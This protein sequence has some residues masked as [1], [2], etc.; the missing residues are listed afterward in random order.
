MEELSNNKME[1]VMTE[2]WEKFFRCIFQSKK[3]SYD[4]Y[5]VYQSLLK[6]Y[7]KECVVKNYSLDFY[8]SNFRKIKFIYKTYDDI[9]DFIVAGTLNDR[10]DFT[11]FKKIGNI[12]KE[13]IEIEMQNNKIEISK[14]DENYFNNIK[15]IKF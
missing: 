7:F 10:L 12:V 14:F 15:N 3:K 9:F 1:K 8:L 5:S 13:N 6:F 11:F 4:N 2:T